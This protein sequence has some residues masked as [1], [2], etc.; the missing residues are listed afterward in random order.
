MQEDE[1]HLNAA[2]SRQ[3]QEDDREDEE[4]A[5]NAYVDRQWRHITLV[6]H[7]GA[8]TDRLQRLASAASRA[9]LLPVTI[10]G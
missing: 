6:S 4:E 7:D 1:G 2:S 8:W 9:G 10:P 3:A 5:D